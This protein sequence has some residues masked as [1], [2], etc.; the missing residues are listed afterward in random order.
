MAEK[1]NRKNIR[2][3]IVK[4]AAITTIICK[5]LKMERLA[6]PEKPINIIASINVINTQIPKKLRINRP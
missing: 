3:S 4:N 5:L 2:R 6:R 1:N